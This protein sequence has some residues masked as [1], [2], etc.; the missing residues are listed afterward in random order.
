MREARR[1]DREN[2]YLLDNDNYMIMG[3]LERPGKPPVIV[4]VSKASPAHYCV[5]YAGNGKYFDTLAEAML[6][7]HKRWGFDIIGKTPAAW[8]PGPT[9]PVGK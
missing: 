9:R 7:M 2:P 6:Y 5:E 3:R 8:K 4:Q 1:M